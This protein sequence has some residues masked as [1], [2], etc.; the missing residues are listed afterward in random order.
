MFDNAGTEAHGINPQGDIVGTYFVSVPNNLL[1]RGFLWSKGGFTT[2][3][4]VSLPGAVAGTAN[5]FGINS[6]RDIVGFY[7]DPLFNSHGFLLSKGSFTKIDRSF[8]QGINPQGDIVGFPGFL[9]SKGKFTNIDFPGAATGSTGANGINPQ[10]DIVG[11]YSDSSGNGHGFLLSHGRFTTID[12]PGASGGLGT[13][14][15]GINPK[16]DIVGYYFDGSSNPHGFLLSNGR[17]HIID[18]PAAAGT[19]AFGI[20]PQ[21]DIVGLYFDDS[22]EHGFLLSKK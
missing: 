14:P 10:G 19:L 11:N 6:R 2:I 1:V 8:P 7:S 18:V 9:L 13:V 15:W 4:V 5:A 21:G 12:V 17:I 22:G 20:N 16:G 3:D